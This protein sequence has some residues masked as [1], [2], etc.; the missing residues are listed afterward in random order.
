MMMRFGRR[1]VVLRQWRR[2]LSGDE[3]K[4]SRGWVVGGFLAGTAVVLATPFAVFEFWVRKPSYIPA[5]VL[6]KDLM[7]IY[8]EKTGTKLKIDTE[9]ATEE[10]EEEVAS[11]DVEE[12][13]EEQ[14]PEEEEE[15]EAASSKVVSV[16]MSID[17]EEKDM[18]LIRDFSFEKLEQAAAVLEALE[19]SRPALEASRARECRREAIELSR[20]R[21]EAALDAKERSFARKEAFEMKSAEIEAEEEKDR[22][23]REIDK[24]IR[25]MERDSIK[26][27]KETIEAKKQKAVDEALSRLKR[28]YDLQVYASKSSALKISGDEALQSTRRLRSIEARILA[29]KWAA[30]ALPADDA[31]ALEAHAEIAMG[32]LAPQTRRDDLLALQDR[33]KT[34]VLPNA[35][36]AARRPQ[37][38]DAP[39]LDAAV[40]S[41]ISSMELKANFNSSQSTEKDTDDRLLKK[42]DSAVKERDLETA[43]TYLDNLKDHKVAILV[44]DWRRAAHKTAVEQRDKQLRDARAIL[45]AASRSELNLDE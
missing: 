9:E 34:K 25:E 16:L 2:G 21:T 19:M 4:S 14:K 28:D 43:L 23:I 27:L 39:L 24:E 40:G 6:E 22:L 45:L 35:L 42:V 5:Y 18:A 37:V 44:R 11:D 13:E 26:D 10:A 38:P 1:N 20:A 17:D 29:A 41:F 33:W 31:A 30:A 15:V 36:A 7:R 32:I 3:K 8:A 12:E